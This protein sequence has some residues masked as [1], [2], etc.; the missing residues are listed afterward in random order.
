MD[1]SFSVPD[2][3]DWLQTPVSLL[4]PVESALRCQ[5]CKDFFNTPM[6]TSCSHTFC[7]LCIRRCLTTDGRC[8]SCRAQDQEIKLRP[9]PIVQELVDTFQV[10][11]PVIL[12][13]GEAAKNNKSNA[14]KGKS[15]RKLSDTDIG[16]EDCDKSGGQ[17][18]RTRLQHRKTAASHNLDSGQ[19]VE[20]YVDGVFELGRW[21]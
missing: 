14:A 13:L 15:K 16:K 17:E 18:R 3:S 21:V 5:V 19:A 9:N 7:S 12:Q 10:A 1:S 6:I 2:P 11:R 8:P 20:D 4:G